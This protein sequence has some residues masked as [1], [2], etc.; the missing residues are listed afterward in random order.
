MRVYMDVCC[1]SRPF[2]DLTQGRVY[3][4]AEAVLAV[5]SR[6]E[7]GEWVLLSSGAIDFEISQI[8]D[9]QTQEKI[10]TLYSSA[11]EY[12]HITQEIINRAKD[13]HV[14]NIGH[15]DSLHLAIAEDAIVDVLL[16]TDDRFVKRAQKIDAR[17]KVANPVTWLMEVTSNE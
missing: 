5:I 1:L 7:D 10:N 12:H 13:F 3:L 8:Q 16:T 9:I 17:I 14:H 4:E 11:S 15:F 2:D 6:C